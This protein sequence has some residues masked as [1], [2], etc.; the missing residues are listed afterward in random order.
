[1]ERWLAR[2]AP[3]PDRIRDEYLEA[4]LE[5]DPFRARAI[6]RDAAASGIAVGT[7]YTEVFAPVL[8]EVGSR[9]ESGAISVAHEHLAAE[10]TASLVSE[11]AGRL[12]L[13]P[14][15]GRLAIVACSPGER[16]CVGGQ[17]LTGLLE[18]EAWEVLYL[19]ATLPVEDLVALADSEVPD[20]V[21]LSTTMR[22]HLPDAQATVEA[23]QSLAEPPLVAVGGQAY[24]SEEA[25]HRIGADLWAPTALDAPALIRERVPPA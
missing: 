19:G 9:W 1:T 10:V 5:P 14:E 3:Q 23:L 20:V 22:D 16:H 8:I 11:L 12:R 2:Q 13:A 6:A 24:E 21:A 15:A 4:V 7:L 18:G 17:M 25:A